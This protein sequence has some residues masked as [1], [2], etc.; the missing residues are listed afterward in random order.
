M[1]P[2]ADRLASRKNWETNYDEGTRRPLVTSF[3]DFQYEPVPIAG[4]ETMGE[5]GTK[6]LVKM[7]FGTQ[8][9]HA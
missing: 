4:E 7:N 3:S 2:G 8:M 6:A 5:T 9:V 1:G